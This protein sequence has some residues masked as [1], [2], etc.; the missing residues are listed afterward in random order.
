MILF[1]SVGPITGDMYSVVNKKNK[2]GVGAHGTA[3]PEGPEAMYSQVDKSKK[4]RP[5]AG[6][7]GAIPGTSVT[8][9][10]L[11]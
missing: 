7:D 1:D 11:N 9:G 3:Q 5:P 2:P 8:S 4:T 10:N 6:G